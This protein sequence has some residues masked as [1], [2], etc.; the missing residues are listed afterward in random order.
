MMMGVGVAS[1]TL[2]PRI[3]YASP[4]AT[5]G[6]KARWHISSLAPVM[7]MVGLTLLAD[8]PLRNAIKAPRPDCTV[9]M[10]TAQLPGSGCESFG[11]LS[12]QSFASWGAFGGGLGIF[13]VDTLKYSNGEFHGGAFV[14]NVAVPFAAAIMTSVGRGLDGSGVAHESPEQI[15][16]GVVPG[17]LLG[18]VLGLAYSF[19]QEPNCGYGDTLF[20]W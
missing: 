10:T 18:G 3:Y 1:V 9:D 20:C 7:S 6:W 15:I 14:G 11:M 8:G 2:M 5:V 19:L 4:D 16:G 13:L 17:M 12:T